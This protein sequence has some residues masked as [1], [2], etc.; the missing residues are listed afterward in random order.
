MLV[1]GSQAHLLY[2]YKEIE[3]I[4]TRIGLSYLFII[5]VLYDVF[6]E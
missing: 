4:S 3:G 2:N 6:F 1:T 5:R